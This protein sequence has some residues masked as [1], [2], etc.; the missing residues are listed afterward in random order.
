[1][2]WA[3]RRREAL[4]ESWANGEM[5]AAFDMEMAVKNAGATGGCSVYRELL[6]LD[7]SDL[8]G[9]SDE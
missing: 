1:M 6:N 8:F 3:A 2:V 7:V 4:K 5:S 9:D